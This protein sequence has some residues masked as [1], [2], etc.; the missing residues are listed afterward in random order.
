M[1][2]D[3]RPTPVRRGEAVEVIGGARSLLRQG[4][5]LLDDGEHDTATEALTK[6]LAAAK[7]ALDAISAYDELDAELARE[8]A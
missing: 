4:R 8:A 3:G 2:A 1:S 6:S 7:D 5:S